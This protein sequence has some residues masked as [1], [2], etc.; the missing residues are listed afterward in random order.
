LSAV[1]ITHQPTNSGLSIYE[2]QFLRVRVRLEMAKIFEQE[3]TS[4]L[5]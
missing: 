2:K 3:K 4:K 5:N 1:V